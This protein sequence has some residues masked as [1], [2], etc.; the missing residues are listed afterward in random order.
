MSKFTFYLYDKHNDQKHLMEEMI[1]F[2]YGF[3]LIHHEKKSGQKLKLISFWQKW[4]HRR[5]LIISLLLL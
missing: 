5:M 4:N 3:Q 1:F 2:S